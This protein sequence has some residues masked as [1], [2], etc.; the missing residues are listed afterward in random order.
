[1]P[2]E[3]RTESPEELRNWRD[4][5]DPDVDSDCTV[6]GVATWSIQAGHEVIHYC[7]DECPEDCNLEGEETGEWCNGPL[8]MRT[9]CPT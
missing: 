9:T 8:E 7:S 1:M 3:S 2:K 6:H 4:T 5:V